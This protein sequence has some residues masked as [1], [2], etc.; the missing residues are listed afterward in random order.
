[1]KRLP[2]VGRSTRT[3]AARQL[4]SGARQAVSYN[5]ALCHA[6]RAA[7]Q[8]HG[9]GRD[10]TRAASTPQGTRETEPRQKTRRV[11]NSA[12]S[13]RA[14][15]SALRSRP[16]L[17]TLGTTTK[18]TTKARGTAPGKKR[19]GH[20]SAQS[21]EQ[22]D[23]TA[24]NAASSRHPRNHCH[25]QSKP[26]AVSGINPPPKGISIFSPARGD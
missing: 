1:M 17:P 16:L 4:R 26:A 25:T 10:K 22:R 6:V 12:Q 2:S 24:K 20:G 19:A 11:S 3:R 21:K 18:A 13:E 15:R 7:R 23:E 9:A 8:K 5:G 14:G